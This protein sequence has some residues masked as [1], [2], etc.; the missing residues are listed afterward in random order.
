MKERVGLSLES[1]VA[2]SAVQLTT[3]HWGL[4][5]GK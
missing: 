1:V 4:S 5:F 3:R 2:Y